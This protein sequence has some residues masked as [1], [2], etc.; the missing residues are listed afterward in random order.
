VAKIRYIRDGNVSFVKVIVILRDGR[1][2]T[3]IDDTTVFDIDANWHVYLS[4]AK[5]K[6]GSRIDTFQ[7]LQLSMHDPEVSEYIKAKNIHLPSQSLEEQPETFKELKLTKEV[8]KLIRKLPS[9][10]KSQPGKY[11]S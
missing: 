4:R 3:A 10:P 6:W 8:S 1:T 5:Q 11:R 9:K 2:L 7:V